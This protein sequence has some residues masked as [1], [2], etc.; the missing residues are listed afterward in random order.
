MTLI[1]L[2]L[3]LGLDRALF[4]HR[5][6]PV[7]RWYGGMTDAIG[8]RLPSRFDGLGAVVTIVAPVVLVIA[9]VQWLAC[10]LLFGLASLVLGVIVLLFAFGPLDVVGLVDDYA[11]ASAADDRERMNWIHGRLTGTEPPEDPHEEARSI[12]DAVLY[13]GHDNLFAT[14]FWFCLLGPAGAVLYRMVAEGAL[15]PS[16]VIVARPPLQRAYRYALGLLGWIPARLIAFGYAMTGS[17]EE[18]LQR[19]RE[20]APAA[21]DLLASNRGMLC[22][23]GTAALRQDES[24][25][26]ADAEEDGERR[27]GRPGEAVE[28]ARSLVLRAAVFWLAILALLTLAGWFG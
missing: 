17:F 25:D 7:P 11:D 23:T 21:D 2:L 13:Q 1:S 27:T 5:D 26:E 10:G 8:A 12:V 4:A 15:R 3:A 24:R 18:A 19:L 14:V 6:G 16:P 20:G 9:L 22:R 28:Q